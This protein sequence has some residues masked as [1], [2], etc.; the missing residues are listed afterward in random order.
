M[1]Y[2]PNPTITDDNRNKVNSI[3]LNAEHLLYSILIE[4]KL[5]NTYMT[6]LTDEHIEEGDI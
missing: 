5:L 6:K 2:T 1:S 3:D 4:L